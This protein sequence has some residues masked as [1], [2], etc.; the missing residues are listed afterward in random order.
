MTANCIDNFIGKFFTGNIDDFIYGILL[1]DVIC[2]CMHQM[3]FAHANRSI[4]KKWIIGSTKTCRN[5]LSRDKTQLITCRDSKILE[6][7]IGSDSG[8]MTN[9]ERFSLRFLSSKK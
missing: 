2:D 7:K 3:S 4:Q 9:S 5:R 6:S 8:K 1:I